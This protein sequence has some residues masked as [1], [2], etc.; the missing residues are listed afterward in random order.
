VA[1]ENLVKRI[2]AL[3]AQYVATNKKMQHEIDRLKAYVDVQNL[4]GRYVYWHTSGR[5]DKKGQFLATKT[6]G[7]RVEYNNSGVYEGTEGLRR[8]LVGVHGGGKLEKHPGQ[9][10]VHPLTTPVVEVAGDCKTA[11]G[12][13]I[14]PGFETHKI[15]NETFKNKWTAFMIWE[16]YAADFVKED[17]VWKW[18]RIH[19]NR[20]FVHPYDKSWVDVDVNEFYKSMGIGPQMLPKDLQPDRP[21]TFFKMYSKEDTNSWTEG[22]IPPP[23]PYETFE[24]WMAVVKKAD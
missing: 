24:E 20:V 22:T 23:E 9:L 8:F 10:T 12:I 18:W 21:T 14:S 19:L 13:W 4:M 7:A 1:N 2:D 16:E 6:E 11:R 17:G 15:N 3:E 5:N